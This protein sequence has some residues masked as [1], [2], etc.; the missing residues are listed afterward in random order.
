M[1]LKVPHE[2]TEREW[3][4][5]MYRKPP[6]WGETEERKQKKEYKVWVKREEQRREKQRCIVSPEKSRE[7]SPFRPRWR[8]VHGLIKGERQEGLT[9]NLQN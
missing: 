7:P 8:T 3:R 6:Y 4:R 2:F 9:F 1:E 5:Q